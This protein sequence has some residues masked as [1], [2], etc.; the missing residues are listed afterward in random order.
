MLKLVTD[1][2]DTHWLEYIL[3]EFVRIEKASFSFSIISLESAGSE[4]NEKLVYYTRDAVSGVSFPMRS[5]LSAL[6]PIEYIQDD[7]YILANTRVDGDFTISYDLFWNAFAFLSRLEEYEKEKT[8]KRINS[9]SNLHPRLDKSTFE[10]P[11]VNILFR[12]LRAILSKHFPELQFGE[13]ESVE[14]HLSHDLDYIKKTW[15]L[16]LKQTAFNLFKTLKSVGKP[17]AFL[18]NLAHLFRFLF[19]NP[20]YWCFDY[21]RKVEAKY[22]FRSTF[23]VY[24]KTR[25][26]GLKKWLLDPSYNITTNERLQN[27]LKELKEDGYGIGIH[28]SF[29]S[30][31]HPG[32]LAKE[33]NIL[34]EALGISIS[35]GRQHWLRY[36]EMLTPEIHE[37]NLKEDS[38]IGWNDRS[39]FRAGVCSRYRLYS[40][41]ANKVL[42]LW[43]TP[44]LIMDSHLFDYAVNK[45]QINFEKGVNMISSLKDYNN[46]CVSIS[47]HPRT[48]SSDYNWHYAY[49][50]YLEV[51]HQ[52]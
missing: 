5:G 14:I 36:S 2:K 31:D 27:K 19:S 48:C 46:A 29:N 33:K 42:D 30:S 41:N 23:Y 51:I 24:A 3:E 18:Q 28:G 1:L 22:G 40:H 34:E 26:I 44:Q 32:Q 10:L 17:S 38:T 13:K 11:I 4:V 45:Q 8:G 12:E 21:W 15:P 47:W 9:Y 7:V 52:L 25:P 37:Q 20:S 6:T 35:K 39:G 50:K 49:E 16:R 43:V